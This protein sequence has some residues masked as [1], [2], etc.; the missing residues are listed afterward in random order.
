MAIK[1]IGAGFGRTGTHSL[2]LALEELGFG[3]CY[4]MEHLI[5]DHPETVTFWQDL[6][7]DKPVDWDKF[8]EGYQSAV[9]FPTNVLYKKFIKQ[10]PDAKIILT[11]RDPESWYRSFSNTII[12]SANPSLNQNIQMS[13]RLPFNKKL[14]QRLQ[15]L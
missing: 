8:F 3:K 2:K 5:M 10:Y 14:R 11:V 1:I 13:I 6:K 15:V 7:A 4:H 12:K 9:D